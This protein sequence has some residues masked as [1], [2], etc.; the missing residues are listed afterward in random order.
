MRSSTHSKKKKK[1]MKVKFIGLKLDMTKA[2][3]RMKW[4]FLTK[5]MEPWRHM[6]SIVILLILLWHV[7]L[8]SHFM[9]FEIVLLLVVFHKKSGIWQGDSLSPYLFTIG[10]EVLKHGVEVPKRAPSITHL[11]F[12]NDSLLFYHAGICEAREIKKVL[13]DYFH[14]SG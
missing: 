12:A 11:I 10:V 7:F 8:P 3:D 9:F 6:H 4:D 13:K 1:K 5:V 14:L 2:Y